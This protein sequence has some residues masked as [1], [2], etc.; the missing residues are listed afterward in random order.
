MCYTLAMSSIVVL[1]LPLFGLIVIGYVAGRLGIAQTKWISVLNLFSYHIAFP[2]LIF[3]SLAFTKTTDTLLAI[4]GVQV[5]FAVVMLLGVHWLTKL[6]RLSVENRNAYTIGLYFSMSGYVGIAALQAVFGDAAAAEGTAV[7]GAMLAVTL[8]LGIVILEL[9]KSRIPKPKKIMSDIV[10]NPLIWATMVGG[11]IGFIHLPFPEPFTQL[12]TMLAA[13]AS[14]AVLVGLGIFIASNHPKRSA[15]EHAV[16]L[17]SL[18]V[19]VIPLILFGLIWLIPNNDWLR[20]TFIQAVMPVA[21]TS[22]AL[23]EIYPMNKP[24]ISS[25]IVFS[26]LL[27]AVALPIAMWAANFL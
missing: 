6:L 12:I 9:S 26:T 2:A 3:K 13:T 16:A 24:V 17:S 18:K 1:L 19:I 10:W 23:A 25:S 8:S 11:L 4:F 7:V 27:T 20:T 15:L 5:L 21:I 14:P 22:F